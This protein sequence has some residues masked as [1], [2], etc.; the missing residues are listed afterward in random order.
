MIQSTLD[1][2]VIGAADLDQG[3]AYVKDILGVTVPRGGEHRIMGTHNCVMSLG[4]QCYLEI[5]AVNPEA[6]QPERP[7]WFGLDNPRVQEKLAG[8]PGLLTWVVSV[9]D[10]SGISTLHHFGE[11]LTMERNDLQW[12]I[13]V[14]EDGSLPGKG[15]L[16]SLI[17]WHTK[18]H[19]AVN[20]TDLGCSLVK[21]DIFNHYSRR[22]IK[23]L[24]SV[25]ADRLMNLHPI[26]DHESPEMIAHI[27]VPGGDIKCLSGNFRV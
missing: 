19:P 1:H 22:F 2:I 20:M 3:I 5:I 9:P 15:F 26:E 8:Q 23:N 14:P 12:Q 7:R 17:H 24:E 27:R 13:S 4:K 11:I 25:S 18:P 10:F 21:L 16:P 6:I